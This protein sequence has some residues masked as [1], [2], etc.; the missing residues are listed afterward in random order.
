MK[1]KVLI[2]DPLEKEGVEILKREKDIT[3]DEKP[4]IPPEDLKKIIKDYHAL[5]VRSGTKVTADIIKEAKNLKV[6]GRAG[7]GLDNVDVNSASKQGII[8][9][10]APAGNTISTS[11]HTMSMIMALSRNIPQAASS[12]KKGEWK[13]KKFM[14]VELY[15]KVL[16]IVGLGRIGTEVAKRATSFGMKVIAFDPFLAP[17]KAAELDIESVSLDELLK[18]SDYI[19]VHA[20]LTDETKHILNK[21]AFEKMKNDARVINCARGGIVDEPALA[22]AIKNGRIAGAA[23]DVF[24][25][26]PPAEDNP[27]LKLDNI[28][29]TPHLGASTEEAQINVAIDI[30]Q[31]VRDVLLDKG[32]KNAVNVPCLEPEIMSVMQ[33]YFSLAE[34]L[35]SMQSQLVEGYIKDVRIK[36]VGDIIKYDVSPLT[37]AI[38]KGMLTPILQE[39]VNYVN[40]RVIARDRGINIVESKTSDVQDFANLIVLEVRTD[41]T[42]N[43]VMGTLFTKVDPRI[44]KL[45][46]YYVDAVPSGFMLF[47]TNKDVPGVVGS[48]GTILGENKVNIA[49]MTFGRLK[50]GGEAVSILNID[51]DISKELLGKVKNSPNIH[52]VK[53]VKL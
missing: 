43:T 6:V 41:K 30:A 9:V 45:N 20:P 46:D 44:V 14:G 49:G 34:K 25:Q 19:T 13:R 47:I 1:Y 40:A 8:V 39:T 12:L 2:S 17:Q 22:E 10:N 23:V 27:L 28:I 18:R 7:V 42:K 53:L 3:V 50:E 38:V 48:I 15:K 21:S 11:E 32:I 5:I 16:G 26:E 33:P 24:E 35:G 36:Y 29:T 52:D 31:T 51:S 37:L 4:K